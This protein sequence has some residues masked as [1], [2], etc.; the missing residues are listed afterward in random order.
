MFI[1]VFLSEFSSW[2]QK[3]HIDILS[4]TMQHHM[5]GSEGISKS[6]QKLILTFTIIISKEYNDHSPIQHT[7]ISLLIVMISIIKLTPIW[8]I[9]RQKILEPYITRRGRE[10]KEHVLSQRLK[11]HLDLINLISADVVTIRCLKK[12]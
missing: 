7:I 8:S 9:I 12:T 2:H 5:Q 10:G 1:F 11:A 6:F 3:N 4:N